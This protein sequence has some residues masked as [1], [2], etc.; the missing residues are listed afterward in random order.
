MAV[1]IEP[2]ICKPVFW[3]LRF[4]C[5]C[6]IIIIMSVFRR[7]W[8]KGLPL[9]NDYSWAFAHN[10]I[11]LQAFSYYSWV[12]KSTT[13]VSR[14]YFQLVSNHLRTVYFSCHISPTRELSSKFLKAQSITRVFGC[15]L[16][17][18]VCTW[19]LKYVPTFVGI[20]KELQIVCT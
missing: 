16:Y 13:G 14:K 19:L 10:R 17:C 1:Y 4:R 6:F 7:L 5:L 9:V 20:D 8:V 15:E 11:H 18:T 3:R 12:Q 2:C